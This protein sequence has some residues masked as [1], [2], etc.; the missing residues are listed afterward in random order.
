M[1]RVALHTRRP[2]ALGFLV[3]LTALYAISGGA[4]D[5]G[6]HALLPETQRAFLDGLE[7]QERL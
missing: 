4:A 3:A 1:K 7:P 5:D 2:R 6:D